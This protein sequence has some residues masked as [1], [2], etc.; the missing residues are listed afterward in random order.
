MKRLTVL[1]VGLALSVLAFQATAHEAHQQKASGQKEP[2][3]Q[4]IRGELVDTG[5]YLAH[6]ARGPKHI[7]CATKCIAQGMPMG[8]LTDKGAL[9]LI[10]MN[11]DNPDPY[12]QLKE[13]A[14]KTVTVTGVV[15]TRAGMKGIDVSAVR[16]G[17]E[18]TAR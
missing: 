18:T 4:T 5:C 15:M 12:N 11:H 13:M 8:L 14:G 9:Y 1:V 17:A 7:D 10:T 2:L 3:P 16:V 6:A